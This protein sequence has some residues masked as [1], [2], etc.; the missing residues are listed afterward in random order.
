MQSSIGLPKSALR[1]LVLDKT[2][3]SRGAHHM[4]I[5]RS[6]LV[7]LMV[8]T[9]AN[10]RAHA[11]RPPLSMDELD[12]VANLIVTGTVT[13][14]SASWPS[15]REHGLDYIYELTI[16]VDRVEKGNI[17]LTDGVHPIVSPNGFAVIGNPPPSFP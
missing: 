14:V 3:C 15:F 9:T 8:F 5:R 11:E 4:Q 10:V 12:S 1:I 7:L 13:G 2:D 17:S 16:R 6:L